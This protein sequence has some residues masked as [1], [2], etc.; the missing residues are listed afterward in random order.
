[1]K[2]YLL[3]LIVALI[4]LAPNVSFAQTV[5]TTYSPQYRQIL[6]ELLNLLE[7]EYASMLAAQT[8]A[9]STPDVA[10]TTQDTAST[11]QQVFE[12]SSMPVATST[13]P[14][15]INVGAVQA[16]ITQVSLASL[17]AQ[18][19]CD[20]PNNLAM[21]PQNRVI[22]LPPGVYLP[23]GEIYMT[24][25]FPISDFDTTQTYQMGIAE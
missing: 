21:C 22:P 1:M 12:G 25:S 8:V 4:F 5:P 23:T 16:N 19:P 10:S 14:L 24:G 9:T 2:K 15:P 7:Q 6:I 18:Y 3:P 17:R 11:T 20:F 13:Q